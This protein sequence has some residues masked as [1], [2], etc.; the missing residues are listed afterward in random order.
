MLNDIADFW[1]A[2]PRSAAWSSAGSRSG[3]HEMKISRAL[4]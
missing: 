4:K 3:D 1:G 2:S